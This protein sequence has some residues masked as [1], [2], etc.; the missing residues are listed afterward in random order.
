MSNPDHSPLKPQTLAECFQWLQDNLSQKQLS[1]LKNMT[2]DELWQTHFNIDK[3]VQ[4]QI[5]TGNKALQ[6][7]LDKSAFCDDPDL[8]GQIT[9]AFWDHLQMNSP[10]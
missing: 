5:L 8:A 10:R 2:R 7:R 4:E 6:E 9:M 1:D 3:I